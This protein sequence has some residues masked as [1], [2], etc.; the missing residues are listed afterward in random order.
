MRPHQKPCDCDACVDA[1]LAEAHRRLM[2]LEIACALAGL[3]VPSSPSPA[4]AGETWRAP[5]VAWWE[6]RDYDTLGICRCVPPWPVCG[7]FSKTSI[8]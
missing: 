1:L 2:A 3:Q 6:W 7:P 8:A 4:V 5:T